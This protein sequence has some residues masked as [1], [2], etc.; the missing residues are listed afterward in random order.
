MDQDLIAELGIEGLTP[1]EQATII[2]NLNYDIGDALESSLS[3]EQLEEYQSIID[4]DQA[5]IDAWLQHN[6]P[7]FKE[8]PAFKELNE[9]ADDIPADKVFASIA[10]IQFN[11][12]HFEQVVAELKQKAKENNSVSA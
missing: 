3:E 8:T 6:V 1:E 5:V 2:D 12:P 10:W 9:D 11:A 7:H 4:G